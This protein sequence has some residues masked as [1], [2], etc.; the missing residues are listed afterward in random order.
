MR[1]FFRSFLIL[2]LFLSLAQPALAAAAP[3][4]FADLTE[5]LLPAV[6]NISTTQTLSTH[7][8]FQNF[9]FQFPEGSPFNELFQDF[10][11][12][13]RPFMPHGRAQ[14]RKATSLGSGFIIDPKGYIVTNYH[15][16]QDA[17]EIRVI[18]QDDT[19]LKAELVG[20]DKKT[21]LA[22]LKVSPKKDL[23]AV[24]FGE[25]D[26]VRVGDW[27][28]AIGNPYGLGGT[29]TA[30]IISA[31]ARNINSGPYDDY[32]QTDA[33]INRGNSGGPM[34][35]MNGQ[36][37]GINTAIF[38]P[39][40]GSVGIGFAIPSSMAKSVVQ[41]LRDTGH[42]KRGWLG[43]QVQTI[44]PEI[45]K[46][47]GLKKEKGALVSSVTKDGPAEKAGFKTGDLILTF[48]GKD[49]EDMHRLPRLV[50]ET[51]VGKTVN[52]EILRKGEEKTLKVKLGK[53]K[54]H[55]EEG[56]VKITKHEGQKTEGT[57]VK[58]LGLRVT[59]LTDT[60]RQ[61]YDIGKSTQG[62]V[63]LDVDTDS[64]S[65]EAGLRRADVI[66]QAAQ[67]DITSGKRLEELAQKAKKAKKPL[68]L[69]IERE[70]NMIFMAMT[71]GN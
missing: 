36:V 33:S 53:L 15:V 56:E 18:L 55:E 39:T 16:I 59:K 47:L 44:T 20:L 7:D 64:L 42:I 3:E 6:V 21:D 48:D 24:T 63:V 62:V 26:K 46:S 67:E 61:K 58:T 37:I 14:K 1:H 43:V 29:V 4:S 22:L 69:L 17:D 49:V 45:A 2:S 41:Q 34:F 38:S 19:N 70:G 13:Q 52:V 8:D 60:F 30:G 12:Q 31:R 40:G 71:I 9:E 35:N 51:E 32:L 57:D 54:D 10:F 65:Y 5:K 66:T 28:V 11:K 50:A 23:P 27:I 25:S 68:L